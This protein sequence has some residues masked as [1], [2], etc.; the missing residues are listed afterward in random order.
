MDGLDRMNQPR[1]FHVDK[2]KPAFVLAGMLL[3]T[4]FFFMAWMFYFRP[5]SKRPF[6]LIG[7]IDGFLGPDGVAGACVA[8]GVL[9]ALGSLLVLTTAWGNR[10]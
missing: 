3:S 8:F 7:F 1:R 5:D 9:F 2:H 4:G 10:E 6:G